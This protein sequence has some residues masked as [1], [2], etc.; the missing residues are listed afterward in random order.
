MIANISKGQSFR[1]VLDYLF[2]KKQQAELIGGNMLGETAREL[3]AEFKLSRQLNPD[4]KQPV[5][6]ASLSLPKHSD[7]VEHLDSD[8]WYQLAADYL[9]RIGFIDN[10][11]VVVRHFDREHDHVHIVAARVKLDGSLVDDSWERIRS[12]QVIRELEEEYSLTPVQSSWEVQRRGLTK[13]QYEQHRREVQQ[14]LEPTPSVKK[15]IQLAVDQ[16]LTNNTTTEQ[17]LKR[18]ADFGIETKLRT[19]LDGSIS[20]ISYQ[21]SVDGSTV[22]TTGTGLGADYTWNG[23]QRRLMWQQYQQQ[24]YQQ[25]QIEL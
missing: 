9:E 18:L 5:F 12:Q 19:R 15:Q 25:Q 7:Y 24:Q 14:G 21:Y 8:R 10:Q 16:A 13:G 3:A 20:G 2:S 4:I 1:G 6:H 23:V 17:F 22:A 11:Y